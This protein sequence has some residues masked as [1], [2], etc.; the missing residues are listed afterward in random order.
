MAK[1][2]VQ[3]P[4][5]DKLDKTGLVL[6]RYS[7][8]NEIRQRRIHMVFIELNNTRKQFAKHH[9]VHTFEGLL[10]KEIR[11]AQPRNVFID[12]YLDELESILG[13]FI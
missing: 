1:K 6:L 5:L 4:K 12:E 8:E 13:I 11:S 2:K 3:L 10:V 9:H 7:I